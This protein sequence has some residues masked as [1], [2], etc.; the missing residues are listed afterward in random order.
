MN[1]RILYLL[2]NH[3]IMGYAG[4]DM[5]KEHKLRKPRKGFQLQR[6]FLRKKLFYKKVEARRP[7]V[8]LSKE[9]KARLDTGIY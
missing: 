5:P 8:Q 3:S 4:W 7:E 1:Y 9:N 6:S 2:S